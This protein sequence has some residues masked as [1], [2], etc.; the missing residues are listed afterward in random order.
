MGIVDSLLDQ[1]RSI[2]T[3]YQ[4]W[5]DHF[6]DIACYCLPSMAHMEITSVIDA[7]AGQP[8]SAY[9]APNIYDHTAIMALDRLNAG[10][11]SLVA[12][13]SS[14]WH[15]LDKDDYS[16]EETTDEEKEWLEKVVNY[17]F[18]M[19][20][21]P[22]TGYQSAFKA[23]NKSRVAL[24]TGVV[25]TSEVMGRGAAQ[26]LSY[27]YVPLLENNLQSNFEGIVDQN[28]RVFTRTAAQCVQRWGSQC[29]PKV[30]AEADDDKKRNN[31]VMLMHAVV[32]A[33]QF[34]DVK[35]T[36]DW[37]SFYVEVENRHLIGRGGYHEFPFHV[38]H[39]N[40]ETQG[41]YSEGPVSM[42]LSEIMSLNLMSKEEYIAAQQ[43]VNPA[44]ASRD[45]DMNRPN[46]SP[47]AHN[48]GMLDEQGRLLIQP[49]ITQPNPSFARDIITA[50]QSQLNNALYVNLFQILVENGQQTATEAMLRAQEKADL[51]GPSGLS[52]QE[53]LASIVD[54]E[55][56]I[57]GRKRAF[58]NEG[59]MLLT[60]ES[61]EGKEVKVQFTGPLDKARRLPELQGTE[62]AIQMA[63]ILAESGKPEAL[64]RLDEKA[65]MDLTQDIAGAPASIFYTEEEFEQKMKE[66]QEQN[67]AAN[68]L[69]AAQ[70]AG[71]A[72]QDVGGG[73]EALQSAASV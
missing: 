24:G 26:P 72:A 31:P 25:Y 37:F 66:K 67:A 4:P 41:P 34:T 73:I 22:S 16:S 21:N 8:N 1:Q 62:R 47:G 57:L 42:A 54:R 45:D 53:G 65:I 35:S 69:Q 50:K 46:L 29:S 30:Q 64:E 18:K 39:W 36:H 20:Y 38:L 6:R 15:A 61:M 9:V 49:I 3:K 43:W 2:T 13:S 44:T 12:P 51:L 32:P 10:E 48:P 5:K 40:R 28:Y 23:A 11:M 7:V 71:Q 14:K 59:S 63:Q 27:H 17:L 55:I 56:A 33:N 58:T 68:A 19:R 60:P 70:A 52:L